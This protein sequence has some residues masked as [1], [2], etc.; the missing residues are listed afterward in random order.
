M[1]W[2][3]AWRKRIRQVRAYRR[4]G[5]A[6]KSAL[7][8]RAAFIVF[9]GFIG[10]VLLTGGLFIFYAKDLPRPDKIVRREGF[11]TKI[12]DRNEE[13][14]YD[15]FA[16]Q[17]RTPVSLEQIPDHLKNATVAIEDKNFYKHGGFDPTGIFR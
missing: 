14:L 7:A 10:L 6:S 11:S 1:S 16:D 8:S 17:R 4:L 5:K 2:Q 9:V 15:V 13:L 12:Y 3:R